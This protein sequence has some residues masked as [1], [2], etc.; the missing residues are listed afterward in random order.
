MGRMTMRQPALRWQDALP[1]GN[2]MVGA[3]MHGRICDE[4]VLLNHEALWYRG[5]EKPRTADLADLLPELRDLLAKGEYREA[6]DFLQR[7]N[8][9]RGGRW[10]RPYPYQPACDIRLWGETTGP[11]RRYRRGVDFATGLAWVRWRDDACDH[12]RE[13]FVSRADG[14]VALRL[15]AG[16]PGSVS[17]RLCLEAHDRGEDHYPGGVAAPAEPPPVSLEQQID[18]PWLAFSGTFDTGGTFGAAGRVAARGGVVEEDGDHIVVS[19]ADE[20]LVLVKLFVDE[21][22]RDAVP[23]LRSEIEALGADFDALFARHE[24]L[25]RALF[26]KMTLDLGAEAMTN[27]EMLMEAYDGDVPTA[28]VQTMF[29]YGRYLLIC[30]SGD[31]RWP[32]NLQ[33]IWNGDYTPA[34]SADYHNDENLQMN[35][36][37]ALPGNLPETTLPFFD[38]HER[39]LDDYRENAQKVYGCRGILVPIAQTTHGAVHP[40]PWVNWTAG[41][42]WLGQLFYDYYLFTG[43]RDFLRERAVP[44]LKET[45]LF[46]EDFLFEGPDGRLVFSPSLSPENK[47]R[48]PGAS[49]ATVNAAM[50]AAVCRETLENLCEACGLLQIEPDGVAR[51]QAMLEKLPGYEVNE[52]GAMCEWLH[53]ALPDNYRHRHLSHLYPVFPGFAATEETDPRIF[54]ACRV[55]VEKRLEFSLASMCGWSMA[56]MAGIYARLGDGNRALECLDLIARSS[57]GPNLLTYLTDWRPMGLTKVQWGKEIPFQIDANFG[58]SA[59]V[60]EM[61]VFSRPGMI[62]LLPALPDRWAAG[63]ARGIACRG[64]ITVDLEW[65]MPE[66]RLRAVFLSRIDQRVTLKFPGRPSRVACEGVDAHVEPAPEG[67]AYRTVTFKAD[68]RVALAAS[69]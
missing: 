12:R 15:S 5:A 26:E 51:W 58:L 11:F 22:S 13:L 68:A 7:H 20:V 65:N 23:R 59:A 27:D 57:T 3:M 69:V 28:L 31:G 47:P 14:V 35:Y 46:Y 66:G 48:C 6:H 25:H 38:Y 30:S 34:W 19:G 17:C 60:L 40:G 32:A 50:D 24:A 10:L 29:D 63:R 62:K 18:A 42:G 39:F 64:Q 4:Q 52:D 41:A 44:W 33:G 45:A 1:A 53:P 49:L 8:E 37:Q 9:R 61:L 16:K 56:H 2:G 43:D 36:W 67:E 54:E 21:P 55:A